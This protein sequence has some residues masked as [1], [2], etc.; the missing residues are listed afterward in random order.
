MAGSERRVLVCGHGVRSFHGG[1]RLR[2]VGVEV[3]PAESLW[4][5]ECMIKAQLRSIEGQRKLTSRGRRTEN[6]P[7]S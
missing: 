6:M 5:Y 2:Q 3:D 4:I 1:R 7:V